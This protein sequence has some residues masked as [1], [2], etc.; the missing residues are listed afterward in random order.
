MMDRGLDTFRISGYLECFGYFEDTLRLLLWYFKDTFFKYFFDTIQIFKYFGMLLHI[1]PFGKF[2][3]IGGAPP[4][5]YPND[6]YDAP[7]EVGVDRKCLDSPIRKW[8]LV[9]GA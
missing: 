7:K 3:R 2:H 9:S 6:K 5:T 1:V 8:S 4:E